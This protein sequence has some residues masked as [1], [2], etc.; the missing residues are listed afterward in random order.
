MTG[1]GITRLDGAMGTELRARGVRVP[2]FKSSLWSALACIEAPDAVTRLHR[3]YIVAGADIITVNNYAVTP[4]LLARENRENELE[5]LALKAAQCALA[6]RDGAR[7]PARVAGSL[8]PLNTTFDASLV[9]AFDDNIAQYR[10]IVAALNPYVDLYL[11]ET[12]STA[13]EARAAAFVAQESG[14]PFMVSWTIERTGRSLRGGDSLDVAVD[15]LDGLAPDAL[16]VNCTSCNAVTSAIRSLRALTDLPI[17]AYANPVLEEPEGGEPE[18]EISK[19]I[20][21]EDYAAVANGWVADGA[22]VI[23]GCCN[24]NP[25]F[26]AALPRMGEA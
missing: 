6:A 10:R 23:G 11:C 14:K 9:G 2:D 4:V 21:P 24:T 26:I 22:T 16:L 13:E 19:P 18:R 7:R 8:P 5:S 12:L 15:R 1:T 20:G 25:Q 3:E 17:G